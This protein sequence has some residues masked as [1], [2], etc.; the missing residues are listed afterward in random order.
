MTKP[1]TTLL[2]KMSPESRGRVQKKKEDLVR[3]LTIRELRQA[4]DLTQQQLAET[5]KVNQE[6]VSKIESESDMY[7]ST[8]R[9]FLEA[10]GA[11]LKIVAV[12]PDG[13]IPISQFGKLRQ[14]DGKRTPA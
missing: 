14:G 4:L 11:S 6:A 9:R 3:E 7:V 2:Q 10:M 8:L 1:F 12:F 13:E 5:L